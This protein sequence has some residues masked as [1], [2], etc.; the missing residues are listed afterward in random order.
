MVF[1]T[2][3][4]DVLIDSGVDAN[5]RSYTA[6]ASV[7]AGQVVT[8]GTAEDSV[9]PS[10]TDGEDV[11]GVAVEDAAAGSQ[12]TVARDGT[13]VRATSGTGTISTGDWVGS[14]GGTGEAGEVD[15][16][17]V[18]DAKL[19][20]AQGPDAGDGGDVVVE[21]NVSPSGGT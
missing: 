16:A 14:H 19:G 12:V 7:L 4:E 13:K 17:V 11:L 20:I 3:A 2:L 5:L 15:T 10:T 1:R 8:H 18:A 9:T 6:E 21:I